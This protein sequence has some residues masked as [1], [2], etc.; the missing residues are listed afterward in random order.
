MVRTRPVAEP[1]TVFCASLRELRRA[2]GQPPLSV[3]VEAMPRKPGRSTL[4]DMLNT[5]ITTAPDC[6]LVAEFVTACTTLARMS[7]PARALPATTTD[8][9]SWQRRH[10]DLEQQLEAIGRHASRTAGTPPAV[11][12]TSTLPH[13]I[14]AFTGRDRELGY[15]TEAVTSAMTAGLV[16]IFAIDAAEACWQR[17]LMADERAVIAPDLPPYTGPSGRGGR[18]HG[19]RL[20]RR[21]GRERGEPSLCA[22][23]VLSGCIAPT[24]RDCTDY[25]VAAPEQPRTRTRDDGRACHLIQLPEQCGPRLLQAH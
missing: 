11:A 9:A 5:K 13:D 18:R 17:A 23:V 15:L 3:L 6:G 1:L 2:A 22:R 16:G 4:S 12:T 21:C 20:C 19:Y 8:L 7:T 24:D 14:V 10:S 25:G